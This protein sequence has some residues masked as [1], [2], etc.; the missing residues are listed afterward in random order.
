MP[1]QTPERSSFVMEDSELLGT[2]SKSVQ[3]QVLSGQVLLMDY[4]PNSAFCRSHIEGA[5]NICLPGILLRRLKKGKNLSLK[6]LIQGDEGNKDLFMKMA[7]KVPL[8]LYDENSSNINANSDTPFV[9]LLRRLKEVGYRVTYLRG[10]FSEFYRL[11]PH[12]CQTT[13]D[14]DSDECSLT[15][16][17]F[18]RLKIETTGLVEAETPLD[19]RYPAQI[20]P[21]LYL[22]T[23]QDCE[24]FELLS[25]LRIRYVLNVTPNIP[26]C[27]ED[28]GIK[29]MQIPIMD[30]WSQNLAAFFPKAIEFIGKYMR[31]NEVL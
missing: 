10:G 30:H 4:R 1:A 31:M 25:K 11:F 23:K 2:S 14:S 21:Y 6:C 9:L 28:N 26:N 16:L 7:S 27:F 22:G 12:L 13:E 3:E 5:V 20:L 24:N 29:Y 17:G 8:I 18:D 15:D 19:N